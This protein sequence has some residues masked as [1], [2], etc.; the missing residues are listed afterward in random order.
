MDRATKA[1][2]RRVAVLFLVRMVA[3]VLALE[4]CKR[5]F[6]APAALAL[7]ALLLF[8]AWCR[9]RRFQAALEAGHDLEDLL[10]GGLR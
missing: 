5:T 3:V 10:G 9:H 2:M 1:L 7:M 8:W 4:L 6:G